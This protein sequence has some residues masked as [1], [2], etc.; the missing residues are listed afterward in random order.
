MLPRRNRV[1]AD[2]HRPTPIRTQ[3]HR[4]ALTGFRIRADHDHVGE[5]SIA[6]G[7]R[8]C[9]DENIVVAGRIGIA[10][11]RTNRRVEA[12]QRCSPPSHPLPRPYCRCRPCL[13][14]ASS[15]PTP[16]FP[17][18]TV[19]LVIEL[20]TDRRVVIACGQVKQRL[21]SER[22]IFKRCVGDRASRTCLSS[23]EYAVH[24]PIRGKK[25][26]TIQGECR[27]GVTR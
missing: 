14:G 6:R 11:A 13:L 16:M 27:R 2:P 25:G 10:R 19:L 24:R 15:G 9:T 8:V 3:D 12:A 5:N 22:G 23:D 21:I 1:D 17:L 18:P 7:S 26:K 20:A 4:I